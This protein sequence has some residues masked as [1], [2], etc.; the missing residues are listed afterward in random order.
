MRR[1]R[2]KLQDAAAKAN[3]EQKLT[4]LPHSKHPDSPH[5][6]SGAG[7][8]PSMA[9]GPRGVTPDPT[10]MYGS[11]TTITANNQQ[12]RR[13]F[14]ASPSFGERMRQ[15]G[16]G[17]PEPIESRPA[18]N[19]ASGRQAVVEPLRD[20]LSAAPLKVNTQNS[21]RPHGRTQAADKSGPETSYSTSAAAAAAVRKFMP[22]RS[23]QTANGRE[24]IHVQPA[25]ATYGASSSIPLATGAP[26][27]NAAPP[28]ETPRDG[29]ASNGP[30]RPDYFNQEK[31]IKR[32]P[33]PS[34]L[35]APVP[36]HTAQPSISSSVYST[37]AESRSRTE[38]PQLGLIQSDESELTGPWVAPPP[39]PAPAF[40]EST[41]PSTSSPASPAP[42]PET[43]QTQTASIPSVMERRR[44]LR[45]KDSPQEPS[46]EDP[47]VISLRTAN[48]Q[49]PREADAMSTGKDLPLAPPEMIESAD[50]VAVLSAKLL[51]LAH[52]RNNI[53]KSI[54][55]M[56]ELMPKDML[57]SSI[58]V[59]RKREDEKRKVELLKQELADIQQQEF[60]LGLK[61]HRANKRR[62]R[63][64]EF[65]EGGSLWI[66]RIT[67]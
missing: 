56:T 61:L 44:P 26:T 19:G 10:Q 14:N 43:D 3:R 29:P 11:T 9:D 60:D 24:F 34:T 18:W 30:P 58:E 28:H 41:T 8:D 21:K 52:R 22:S 33:P 7:L 45:G 17:K 39:P 62:E 49:K 6:N 23:G 46:G 5:G 65:E 35:H 53:N 59:Q 15:F 51:G 67:G 32:K 48:Y 25:A 55:Q 38:S 16:K 66:R 20:D 2:R 64:S 47:I 63:E 50:R 36:S 57:L 12:H 27:R 40:S 54:Q 4:G 1:E 37:Q 13:N 42:I 31:A